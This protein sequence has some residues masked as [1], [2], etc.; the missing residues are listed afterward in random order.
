MH[1]TVRGFK[2]ILPPDSYKMSFVE[3]VAKEVFERFNY[4][5]I[6]IPT[7][8]YYDLFIK[9]TGE[10]T[11]I[12]EKEMYKFEDQSKRVLALRPEGT[13]GVART[14]INNKLN[15]KGE[16]TKYFYIGN[17]FRAERPQAGRYREF[18]QIG[19][20]CIGVSSP[21][22]D[23][24]VIIMLDM[25]LKKIGIR[26]YSIEIN[27]L[28]CNE[29][30][31]KYREILIN[32]LKNLYLCD[33]CKTRLERNPLRV[34]DCKTDRDKFKDVPSIEL[35]NDC[36]KHYETLKNVLTQSNI[37][38]NENPL[39][40]RGLDY[41]TKT[42]FEIW[43]G[44]NE[45]KKNSLGGGG[46]YDNLIEMIGGEKTP[47]I[48]FGLGMDRLVIEMKKVNAKL[49]KEPKPRV[50]LAQLGELAKKKSLKIFSELEKNGILVAES[51]GR[52]SLK[53]Q[54]RIAD[55]LGVEITLIIGQKEALDGTIIVRDMMSGTQ[56]IVT[57]EKLVS[58]VKK[59]LK[60][61]IV[62]KK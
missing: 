10:T 13:P 47:A 34:I 24:E 3:N 16:N 19:A 60:A 8:E 45:G 58:L 23:A 36:R 9:T 49:Y 18:E 31:K 17:M 59:M 22:A 61:P 50:F 56:E 53:S 33:I 40:V 2:D 55:K 5:E 28:G 1:T 38:F 39:L 41:Y 46:R 54:M 62:I 21:Y 26:S 27:S 51:F 20:E 4:K 25:I 15:L 12:V 43:S 7:V 52:G 6:R 29:C 14:Y 57:W 48:G 35:C 11:D 44:S 30:R 42:V 32:Y 37:S